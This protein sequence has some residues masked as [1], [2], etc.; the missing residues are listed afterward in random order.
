MGQKIIISEQDRNR[1]RG[2]YEQTQPNQ[3]SQ[4]LVQ[5]SYGT[6]DFTN[7][8]NDKIQGMVNSYANIVNRVIKGESLGAIFDY[9]I[10]Q[11]FPDQFNPFKF[12]NTNTQDEN[13]MQVFMAIKLFYLGGGTS[14]L[15]NLGITKP[16]FVSPLTVFNKPFDLGSLIDWY[17]N[18][19]NKNTIEYFIDS[20][21]FVPENGTIFKNAK[22]PQVKANVPQDFLSAYNTI[23]PSEFTISQNGAFFGKEGKGYLYSKTG[24]GYVLN[25]YDRQ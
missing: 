2:L 4:R 16:K 11:Q 17:N 5:T 7:I 1:I 25:K 8:P 24:N 10:M 13:L 12:L 9:G 14:N 21:S 19:S 3:Q 22:V 6:A 20:W 18:P 15:G 23:Q